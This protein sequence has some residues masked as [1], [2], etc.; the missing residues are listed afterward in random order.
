MEIVN[1]KYQAAIFTNATD[2]VPKPDTLT[3]FIQKF[4]DKE[5]IPGTFQEIGPGG[6]SERFNLKDTNGVWS[7][8]FNSNRID[9][10]KVNS[11]IGVTELSS[12]D[13]FVKEVKN[14]SEIILNKFSRKAHRLALVNTYI[15]MDLDN[16]DYSRVFT[17]LF[18]PIPTYKNNDR[19]EWGSRM[20]SRIEN[21]FGDKKE[22]H[23]VITEINRLKGNLNIKS[24]TEN[25]ERIQAKLDINTYQGNSE[26]RFDFADMVS[27]FDQT[28]KW[29]NSLK[30]EIN[31]IIF[32]S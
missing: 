14:I 19:S 13:D 29:Q 9:I 10:I 27:F 8:E 1:I 5:L 12:I 6:V 31:S 22:L 7:I 18:N 28:A 26:P 30:E 3:Y 2:I 20:V 25:V 32:P 15:I 16:K 21:T 24:N 11:N 23:N 4:S 17:K